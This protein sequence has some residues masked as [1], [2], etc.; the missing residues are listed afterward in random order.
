LPIV[1]HFG[2]FEFL[3]ALLIVII[4][5]AH[6]KNKK[7]LKKFTI[8]ALIALLF[9][10]LMVFLL[11]HLIHE[12]RP[13]VSFADVHLL[14][15]EDDPLSFP[16]GHTT[17]TLVVVTFFILNMKELAKKHYRI[18][19]VL[20]VIF[21]IAIPFLI[22]VFFLGRALHNI[23]D[24]NAEFTL[25]KIT[26]YYYYEDNEDFFGFYAEGYETEFVSS[27]ENVRDDL[28]D[29]IDVS[30]NHDHL[31]K[32]YFRNG[33][34]KYDFFYKVYSLRTPKGE[35]YVTFDEINA[36]DRKEDFVFMSIF[37]GLGIAS[38]VA[39]KIQE[40][41]IKNPEKYSERIQKAVEKTKEQYKI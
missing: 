36:K 7:T 25:A 28:M 14:V 24:K 11:K 32:I 4:L 27:L 33:G 37:L 39:V 41:T 9:S 5:Y 17:S 8:L 15:V 29:K 38:T 10:G 6:F 35:E 19:D 12:P 21:A 23:N 31:M 30:M 22:S 16:S 2:G 13:F 20:L 40:N 18:I 1:T 26:E 3:L 34:G